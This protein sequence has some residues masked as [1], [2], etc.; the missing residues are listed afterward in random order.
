MVKKRR[1]RRGKPAGTGAWREM[2]ATP[3]GRRKRMQ[4]GEA[5]GRK[6]LPGLGLQAW[7]PPARAR[8]ESQGRVLHGLPAGA[9][10]ATLMLGGPTSR[11]RPPRA[12]Q[13][14]TAVRASP[15][16]AAHGGG[17]GLPP[18][19]PGLSSPA[20]AS[21]SLSVQRRQQRRFRRL[22]EREASEWRSRAS[23]NTSRSQNAALGACPLPFPSGERPPNPAGWETWALARSFRPRK[24][25]LM[26]GGGRG[27]EGVEGKREEGRSRCRR[28]YRPSGRQ[29]DEDRVPKHPALGR[30]LGPGSADRGGGGV[31][32]KART[33]LASQ[34]LERPERGRYLAVRTGRQ[35]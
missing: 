30:D 24:R 34:P 23:Q 19:A 6:W 26:T 28:K 13:R 14:P 15:S 20:P 12:P 2:E 3:R 25:G 1:Y 33:P 4:G 27:V 22:R 5:I 21:S 32:L 10:E 31:R 7:G 35:E 18:P 9:A 16:P 17:L 11:S 29:G 8:T